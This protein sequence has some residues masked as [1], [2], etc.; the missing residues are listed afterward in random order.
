[1]TVTDAHGHTSSAPHTLTVAQTSVVAWGYNLVGQLGDGTTSTQLTPVP[2]LGLDAVSSIASDGGYTLALRTDG[3]VWGWGDNTEGYLGIPG[4]TVTGVPLQVPGLTGVTA[5][6]AG[7]VASYALSSDGTVWAMGQNDEDQLGNGTLTA[8]RVPA[9]IPGLSN[10]VAVAA[11]IDDGYALRSD[12]TVLA[13]GDNSRDELGDGLSGGHSAGP[14][15]VTG[16]TH[17]TAIGTAENAAYALLAD[18]TIRSWGDNTDGQ[19]GNGSVTSSPLPVQPV[20]LPP[21]GALATG[22]GTPGTVIGANGSVWSWGYN[23][24]GEVGDG[25]TTNRLVPVQLTT[26]TGASTIG[27]SGG[28]SYA[29]F[30]DG[31]VRAWGEGGNGA[32]GDGGSVDRLSPVPVPAL[33]GVLMTGGG[34]AFGMAVVTD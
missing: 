15:Q 5:L 31:T 26:L 3:T 14:V 19:L 22:L 33:K 6:A 11:G 18:G 8:S 20:G 34:E 29:V 4:V 24:D 21:V 10:V 7:Q 30:P 1:V 23:Y 28:A 13:W 9:K 16:L 27:R 2:V 17:V 32:I 25:T 12:G